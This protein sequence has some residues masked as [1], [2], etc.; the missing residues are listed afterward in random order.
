MV[1]STYCECT[2]ELLN[3]FTPCLSFIQR[4]KM[5]RMRAIPA[6]EHNHRSGLNGPAYSIGMLPPRTTDPCPAIS[7][8]GLWRECLILYSGIIE[9]LVDDIPRPVVRFEQAD[10]RED[11]DR[12][13]QYHAGLKAQAREGVH[14]CLPG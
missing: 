12:Q 2:A 1:S 8:G 10:V 13:V 3:A 14:D 7:V 5:R 11:N 9:I 6:T 4:I